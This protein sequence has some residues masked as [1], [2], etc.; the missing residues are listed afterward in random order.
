M[1]I[2]CLSQCVLQYKWCALRYVLFFY[3][4]GKWIAYKYEELNAF[5]MCYSK[6]HIIIHIPIARMN[7]YQQI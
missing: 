6:G 4:N 2:S 3:N 1:P 7:P 5:I